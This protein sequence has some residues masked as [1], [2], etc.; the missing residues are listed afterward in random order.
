MNWEDD[1]EEVENSEQIQK[2]QKHGD[3]DSDNEK[4]K[5]RSPKEKFK[6][7]IKEKYLKIKDA[8]SSQNFVLMHENLE[9]LLKHFD[10]VLQLFT[11]NEFPILFLE[12]LVICE[13][14]LSLSKDEQKNLK[15]ENNTAF[16]NMKKVIG[17]N[18]KKIN[19]LIE[20]YKKDRPTKELIEKELESE[21]EEEDDDKS[22]ESD[23]EKEEK[24]DI[25]AMIKADENKE[26][27][28]R[29]LKWVKKEKKVEKDK[30]KEKEDEEKEEKKNKRKAKNQGINNKFYDEDEEE[31]TQ[32]VEEV[33]TDDKIEK[34]YEE[35]SNQR[36]QSK[37]PIEIVSRLD[38]LFTKTQNLSLKIRLTSISIFICFDASPGQFSSISLELWDKIYKKILSLI[39]FLNEFDKSAP[40]EKDKKENLMSMM[41]NNLISI[42]E[43]L[44]MEL[45]KSLQFTDNNSSEYLER[46]KDEIT[47]LLLCRKIEEFY[48]KHNNNAAI[49]RCYL[50]VMKHI[51]YKNDLMINAINQKF[52]IK[53][54]KEDY[55]L[56]SIESPRELIKKLSDKIYQYLDD[57][58]KLKATLYDIYFLSVHNNFTDAKNLFNLSNSYEMIAT[59]KDEQLKTLFNRTL[60]ELGLSAFR[61]GKLQDAL[62][63]LNPL[64][65]NGTTKLKEY[66]SQSYTKESEKSIMFDKEDKKRAIPHLMQFNIDEIECVF[67]IASMIVDIPYILLNKLGTARHI[68]RFGNFYSRIL[69]NFDKQIFNG[70]PETNKERILSASYFIIKGDWKKCINEINQVKIFTKLK[71][72]SEI[73]QMILDNV[74]STALRCYIIFYLKEYKSFD[75]KCLERRFEIEKGKIKKIIND[76]IMDEEI[77][78]KW[79][80]DVL[81][82]KGDERDTSKMMKKLVENVN[83]ISKQNVDLLEMA[84]SCN[85]KED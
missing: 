40:S 23:N 53:L 25:I 38:Y 54:S 77:S 11:K 30:D 19:E 63:F 66:L 42:L 13:E 81:K 9:E 84:A 7:L 59:F 31:V 44:E 12:S 24:I 52:N 32:K 21:S 18:A 28:E 35:I 82:V 78:A 67:Y 74:K 10:K 72:Y 37:R 76:M 1:E 34:E 68:K 45:Y 22:E 27:A 85:R 15:R 29:R 33:I 70:P 51:Y 57:K 6:D 46:V 14:A 60:A 73:K 41:Q 47:F 2:K 71:N 39:D 58:S 79:R 69:V 26:P 3:D 17:K 62:A 65:S 8:K 36:G 49:A 80:G 55:L 20:N 64:C 43:K 5:V 50:L 61:T 16:N 83:V 56:Q 48:S 4:R 75:V